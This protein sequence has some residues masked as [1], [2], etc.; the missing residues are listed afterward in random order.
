[1]RKGFSRSR[2]ALEERRA[3]PQCNRAPSGEG[4]GEDQGAWCWPCLDF[5]WLGLGFSRPRT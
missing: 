3:A 4:H 5:G 2:K 1:M